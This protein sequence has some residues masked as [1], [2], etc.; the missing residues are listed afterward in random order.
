MRIWVKWPTSYLWDWRWKMKNEK[1]VGEWSY[2]FTIYIVGWHK[3]KLPF[4]IQDDSPSDNNDYYYWASFPLSKNVNS[5]VTPRWRLTH[6]LSVHWHWLW[7]WFDFGFSFG[8]EFGFGRCWFLVVLLLA[9]L[10]LLGF[11]VVFLKKVISEEW[12]SVKIIPLI[13]GNT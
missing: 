3:R 8:F 12:R 7:L 10:L 2:I 1:S 5:P 13:R 11:Y 9:L 6:D 4:N